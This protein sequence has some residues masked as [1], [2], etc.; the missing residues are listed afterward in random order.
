M[1]RAF[2]SLRLAVAFLATG[3]GSTSGA[4]PRDLGSILPSVAAIRTQAQ[5]NRAIVRCPCGRKSLVEHGST[6]PDGG[7]GIMQQR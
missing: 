5:V 6:E 1:T 7:E 3:R 2:N 4:S